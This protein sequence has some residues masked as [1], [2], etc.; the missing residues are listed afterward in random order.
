MNDSLF[1]STIVIILACIGIT[2]GIDSFA[3]LQIAKV[4]KPPTIN[5][6]VSLPASV[7]CDITAYTGNQCKENE[8]STTAIMDKPK[9]GWTCAVSRDL[10][11][12]LGGQV[13]IEG[14]GIRKVNDLTDKKCHSPTIDIYV[15]NPKEASN[16]G[17]QE[18]QVIFLGR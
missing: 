13:Y 9:A 16:F 15:G 10:I 18:K 17:R 11:H 14:I 3:T 12:W 6:F 8:K 5:N 2:L 4:L 1:Q 7:K